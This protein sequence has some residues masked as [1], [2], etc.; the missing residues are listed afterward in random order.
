MNAVYL[1]T[2]NDIESLEK[3]LHINDEVIR[4]ERKALTPNS[5]QRN[6]VDETHLLSSVQ[7]SPRSKQMKIEL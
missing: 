2:K 4:S 6:R 7:L 1:H 3:Y 5:H